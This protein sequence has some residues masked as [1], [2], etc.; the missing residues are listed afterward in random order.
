MSHS[1][2]SGVDLHDL[3]RRWEAGEKI[4]ALAQEAGTSWNKLHFRLMKL[5]YNTER[6]AAAGTP[7]PAAAAPTVSQPEVPAPSP[8]FVEPSWYPVLGY[9]M[10]AEKGITLFGPRGCGKSTAI[11][12]K[13]SELGKRTITLQC[14]ANMQIDSLLGSWTSEN[15][16]LRFIDGPLTTA[17][18]TGAWLIAEEANVIHPGVWSAVNTLTDQTGEGLRL[19]TG[20]VVPQSPDF[21]LALCYNEGYAG[22]REVNCALKEVNPV[23]HCLGFFLG[24]TASSLSVSLSALAAAAKLV[25]S[26]GP[27]GSGRVSRG[28][29]PTEVLRAFGRLWGIVSST[30]ATLPEGF[31]C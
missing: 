23:I 24:M 28:R 1:T 20:E 25:E 29:A 8:S 18:R 9:A 2:T 27:G 31:G 3:G 14:A 16:S 12:H 5:G 10:K 13:A 19:P 4:K 26:G 7:P 15:G 30:Q 11:R 22:T 6:G 17:V 21:R